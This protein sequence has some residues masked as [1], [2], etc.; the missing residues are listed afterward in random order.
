MN[1]RKQQQ[2]FMRKAISVHEATLL[3]LESVHVMPTEEVP[4]LQSIGRT[5]AVE[6]VAP[7]PMPHFR[8]SGMDGF[9]VMSE[10]TKQATIGTPISLQ[11]IDHVPAGMVSEKRLSSGQCIRIMTGAS[12][13]DGADAVIKYEM[14]E[15]DI[16]PDGTEMCK[17]KGSVVMG[18]N[19]SPIGVE[20]A[21]NETVLR[22]GVRIGSG[23]VALLA[24]FGIHTVKVYKQPRVAILATGAELLRVEDTL[25]PGRIRNSNAYMLAAAITEFGGIPI[26]LDRVTD[27]A[28][29]AKQVILEALYDHDVVVTTGGVSVGDHDILYDITQDWDGDLLFNKVMMRPGSP[30][31]FGLWQGKPLFALSGNPAACYVGS[32]LFLRPALRGMMGADLVPEPRVMATLTVDYVKSDRFTRFV[33]GVMTEQEGKL[34]AA[35]VGYDMSSVTV[36]LRDANCLICLPGSPKGYAAG[37][38][39]EVIPLKGFY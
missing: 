3:V 28:R 32:R 25:E 37:S 15:E 14:T 19:V 18:E 21:A 24:M 7:Q 2:T 11:I 13:P 36:S 29:I 5:L 39:V 4:I 1:G 38:F 17:V 26:V 20:I 23:E 34:T 8:R 30:T 33:R 10:D 12:V 31:T 9:A 35:P 6:L 16:S 22:S 27:D